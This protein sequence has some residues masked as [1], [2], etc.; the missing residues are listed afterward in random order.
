ME[1]NT[2]STT[3]PVNY[4]NKLNT[5]ILNPTVFIIVLLIIIGYFVF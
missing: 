2:T 1:V 5:F 4:Y 3:D